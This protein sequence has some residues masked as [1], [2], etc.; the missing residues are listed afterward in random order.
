MEILCSPSLVGDGTDVSQEQP[1]TG[2]WFACIKYH[3][4]ESWHVSA[5]SKMLKGRIR[6]KSW[7]E[8]AA[9]K[10]QGLGNAADVKLLWEGMAGVKTQTLITFSGEKEKT[11]EL[12][13]HGKQ[14]KKKVQSDSLH[15]FN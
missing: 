12:L 8:S 14:C 6:M 15:C 13:L 4:F 9:A 11:G 1:G 2:F 5:L 10:I 7:R 3:H